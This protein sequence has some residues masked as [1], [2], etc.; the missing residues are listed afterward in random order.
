VK[1]IYPSLLENRH[2]AETLS[3]SSAPPER[4]LPLRRQMVLG[5]MGA[6]LVLALPGCGGRHG[7]TGSEVD[8]ATTGSDTTAASG[9]PVDGSINPRVAS[10][11][12]HPGL[13]HTATD[14][15]RMREKVA[16]GLSPWLEGWTALTGSG[17]ANLG[18][19]PRPLETVIRGGDGSNYAQMYIDVERAYQL[20]LR[21]Q[22]SG[23]TAYADLAVQF[24]N[25]WS[26]TL[27]TLTG[28]SDRFLAA[29][30][31]GYQWANAAEIMRAYSGWSSAGVAAFQGMLTR[32]FYPL[33]HEFLI[34]HNGSEITNYWANWDLCAI[35]AIFAIGVFCDRPDYCNEALSYYTTGRGNGAGAHNVYVLHPG[36]LGQWQE[37]GRD[38]GHATLGI[39]LAG[40][41]CEMAW[42]QGV[43]LYGWRNNR[44]LAGAEYVAKSNLTDSAGN[45]YELPFAP[46]VNRQGS[47]SEVSAAARPH[48]RPCWESVY[49]HYVRRKGLAAPWV[50][51]MAAA[52]RPEGNVINGDQLGMGTLTFTREDFAGTQ[53]PTGLS[54]YPQAGRVLLSWWGCASGTAY[55]VQRGSSASGPFTTVGTVSGLLTWT[56]A[57]GDGTWHYAVSA[58]TASG[59]TQRSSTVRVVL[60]TDVRAQLALDGTA[61]DT[62]GREAHGT[63]QGGATWDAGRTTGASLSLDGQSGALALPDGLLAD[64]ADVSVSVWVYWNAEVTNTRVWD[65]GTSDI[66]YLA[67]IPKDSNGVLRFMI[68]GTSH[69]GEQSVSAPTA[70]PTGRWVH[71]AVTLSGTTARLYVDGTLVNSNTAISL[72]PYQLG[73]T[74]QNW[75]GRSQY[76]ADPYLSGRLQDFRLHSGALTDAQVAALAGR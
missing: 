61:Q 4:P 69:W 3:L 25:A 58:V 16:A 13:L 28:N 70:L 73:V 15:A 72:A 34:S 27:T 35:N 48:R 64:L 18:M 49:H 68:T 50:S 60:P 19:V 33:A 75:L 38:Q 59:E 2:L 62:S 54:A 44:L 47:F 32:L 39:S 65:F 66:A 17:H 23:D 56:D 45:F 11:L 71:V 36:H 76:A 37:A 57:P 29:G 14:M 52:T 24:L 40:A 9:N 30:I 1:L 63:L 22:V 26:A 6:P 43:D 12:V 74:R 31:Y 7:S 21:W 53:R 5:L 51:A 8:G 10:T 67:L 42:N 55:Q 46:Y 20:A 41:L